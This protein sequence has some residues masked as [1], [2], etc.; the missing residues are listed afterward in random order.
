[1][2]IKSTVSS[3]KLQIHLYSD[4][5]LSRFF[6]SF[7]ISSCEIP[8]VSQPNTFLINDFPHC[9]WFANSFIFK[10]LSTSVIILFQ[11]V[12]WLSNK[13]PNILLYTVWF[14][15]NIFLNFCS[16]CNFSKHSITSTFSVSDLTK[17]NTVSFSLC[18][19]S[20]LYNKLST[21]FWSSS[22]LMLAISTPDNFP[23]KSSTIFLDDSSEYS[24]F[25]GWSGSLIIFL[26]S[27]GTLSNIAFNASTA[28]IPS[29]ISCKL[30]ISLLAMSPKNCCNFF[31]VFCFSSF[32]LLYCII[33]SINTLSSE[34]VIFSDCRSNILIS[35]YNLY[36]LFQ[37]SSSLDISPNADEIVCS[38][39]MLFMLSSPIDIYNLF[40]KSL[41]TRK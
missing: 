3:N 29:L 31:S 28:S 38:S 16:L 21:C 37:S 32:T 34:T 27:S 23:H 9:N 6:I 33:C 14:S 22:H 12:F 15:D 25:N 36:T 35:S 39:K 20:Q 30:L 4:S 17:D 41:A 13:M 24:N 18:N 7:S 2:P 1:M 19:S 11:F 40:N 26:T 5:Q 10:Q 8:N